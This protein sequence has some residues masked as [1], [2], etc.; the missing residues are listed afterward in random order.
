MKVRE[1]IFKLFYLF[2]ILGLLLWSRD[3]QIN[4]K[5]LINLICLSFF[6]LRTYETYNMQ[7]SIKQHWELC[8][9]LHIIML[10]VK[11]WYVLLFTPLLGK[12]YPISF[13]TCPRKFSPLLW[14]LSQNIFANFL[15]D[16][17]NWL[18]VW[19]GR[20]HSLMFEI[21]ISQH[22]KCDCKLVFREFSYNITCFKC[23]NFTNFHKLY[24][25]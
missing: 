10:N 4:P 11:C 5:V 2:I 24:V 21:D 3:V 22:V 8:Y 12:K 14:R 7:F 20:K 1:Q 9:L 6:M 13:A 23:H 18:F 19:S 15:Q 16:R 17:H 25:S